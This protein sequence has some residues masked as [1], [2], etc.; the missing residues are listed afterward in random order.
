M[1]HIYHIP[2]STDEHPAWDGAAVTGR[3]RCIRAHNVNAFTVM[4]TN[5]WIIIEPGA[6]GAL[7]VDPGP[8]E[9]AHLDALVDACTQAG[10]RVAAIALTHKHADHVEGVPAF[11]ERVGDVPVYGRAPLGDLMLSDPVNF[12]YH[13]L[14]DGP[15]T[16]FPGC[17]SLEVVSLPGHASDCV[18]ILLN[19]EGSMLTGDMIFRDWS[20]II[21]HPDGTLGDYFASLDTLATLTRTGTVSLLLTGH[22][23]PIDDPAST[24]A[25]YA[26]HRRHRLD[27]LRQAIA[28][29]GSTDARTLAARLYGHLDA[30]LQEPG[31]VACE[32]QL[33]YLRAIDDP[34]L[35]R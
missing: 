8:P 30:S 12:S 11:I 20:T 17:P 24:I 14:P 35:S 13:P 31:V 5:S 2:D 3:A 6:Q 23:C 27:T 4:G 10:A 19:D 9:P 18:G 26:A 33:A 29:T 21:V 28:A 16:P 32:A 15:F 1:T 22:G 25:S 34:C 7:V